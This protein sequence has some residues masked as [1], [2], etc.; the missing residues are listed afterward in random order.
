MLLGRYALFCWVATKGGAL[1]FSGVG[2]TRI[3]LGLDH[4]WEAV[5]LWIRAKALFGRG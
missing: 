3:I 2:R 5:D 4:S 1:G